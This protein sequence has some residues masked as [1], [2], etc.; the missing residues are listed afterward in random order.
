MADVSES[1]ALPITT[2]A[3]I[4]A[5][6][7]G[8]QIAAMTAASGR[9]VRLYDVVP[10]AAE[11]ALDRL[12]LLL[13]PVIERGE[14]D[15]AL[16]SVLARIAPVASLGD[17]VGGVDL[18]IEAVREDLPTKRALFAEIAVLNPDPLLATNSSSLPSS[19]LADV[20]PDPGKLVNLHFFSEFWS[21]SCVE[22]MG[23]GRTTG[24][25]MSVLAD[26]GRSLG[27]YTAVVRGESKGFIINR[28]WRAVKREA[29]AVVD[30]GHADPEDVDRLWAFFWDIDYGPFAMMDHVGLNVVADIED[31]YIA[32]SRDPTDRPSAAL[33]ELVSAGHLGE[34]TGS[35][36]YAYPNPAYRAPGWPRSGERS[37]ER[38]E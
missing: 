3:V 10:G 4:G 6:T 5:G 19:T 1:T 30:G 31:S 34:K 29:L 9:T 36:F 7:L 12:R 17:A 15:W 21:R 25:T 24:E 14:L 16:E 23:C 28:V 20:V 8:A 13:Q 26:F 37:V 35:G 33:H 11:A 38:P 18:V 2:V 22:L 27:L 32:V